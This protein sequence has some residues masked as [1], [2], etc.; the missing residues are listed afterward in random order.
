M[1]Y[2]HMLLQRHQNESIS[3]HH[4][5]LLLLSICSLVAMTLFLCIVYLASSGLV[6]CFAHSELRLMQL[7][8]KMRER[9]INWWVF[10]YLLLVSLNAIAWEL[11][12][13]ARGSCRNT[14][15]LNSISTPTC[16]IKILVPNGRRFVIF[17]SWEFL[18]L[19]SCDYSHDAYW[20]Q[21]MSGLLKDV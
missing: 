11:I 9:I 2:L 15:S 8:L 6:H 3:L 20:W 18:G 19:F 14:R 7:L 12:S 5:L 16:L 17:V 21:W 10:Y 1:F 13:F 4:F